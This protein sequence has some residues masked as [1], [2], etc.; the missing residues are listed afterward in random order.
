VAGLKRLVSALPK[1]VRCFCFVSSTSV[2]GDQGG[3]WVDET[4]VCRPESDAGRTL[5]RA[6]ELLR[7]SWLADRL[8][9]MRLAGLYG[10]GR[11]PS[12][13]NGGRSMSRDGKRFVNLIHVDDAAAA[14]DLGITRA[15]LPNLFNLS[16]G[17]PVTCDEFR[18]YA[19]VIF[20]KVEQEALPTDTVEKDI[21][22]RRRGN[23]R[24][25]VQHLRD[26]LEFRCRYVDFRAGLAA[27]RAD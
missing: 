15:R 1:T 11:I 5:L 2:Y 18:R 26:E 3:A 13:K 4:A 19:D 27:S 24:I 22:H 7:G 10:T 6:E 8:L 14:I 17:N 21:Y 23:K 20:G 25:S 9:I 16:D 12:A